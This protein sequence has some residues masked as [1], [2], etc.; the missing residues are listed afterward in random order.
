VVIG[1]RDDE[2]SEIKKTGQ[3]TTTKLFQGA[4][5]LRKL[6]MKVAGTLQQSS[7]PRVDKFI[8]ANSGLTTDKQHSL[9]S[10]ATKNTQ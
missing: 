5:Y 2:V 1:L 7:V 8:S 10:T 3:L 6:N 9:N 4:D